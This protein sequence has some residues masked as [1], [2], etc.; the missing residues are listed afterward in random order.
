MI[1]IWK[2]I[3]L[4][5]F[6]GSFDGKTI[7][8]KLFPSFTWHILV[9]GVATKGSFTTSNLAK[10][11][12]EAAAQRIITE[13]ATRNIPAIQRAPSTDHIVHKE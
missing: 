12:A 3:D 5:S 2:E 13:K 1:I 11:R 9:D 8:V 10:S 6:R 4:N 7:E